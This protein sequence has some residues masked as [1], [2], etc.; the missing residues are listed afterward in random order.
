MIKMI[1]KLVL[2]YQY[3]N[4]KRLLLYF[5]KTCIQWNTEAAPVE[6]LLKILLVWLSL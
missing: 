6:R 4:T 1:I 2:A 3:S 5:K